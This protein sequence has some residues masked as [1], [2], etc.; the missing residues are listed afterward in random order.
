MVKLYYTPTSCGAASFIAA[1]ANFVNLDVEQV[2]L[3]THKT[4]S[5]KDYYKINPKG[6]V[7]AL[8]LDNGAVLNEGAAVLQWIADRSQ[9]RIA[10]SRNSEER[11]Y[12]QNAL[13]Y[14]SSEVHPAIGS[15]FAPVGDE[16]KA[17]I[18]TRVAAKLQFVND[19]LIGTKNFVANN[20]KS[21]ADY[22]LYICLTWCPFVGIDLEPYTNITSYVKK[23]EGLQEVKEARARMALNPT[24]VLAKEYYEVKCVI[25]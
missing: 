6:N 3:G 23:M 1:Y 19:Q 8:V 16:V 24:K 25:A 14:I 22:Y 18:Q 2:D 7:P 17:H 20:T 11:Y 21:V 15:F 9:G 5:G 4:S 10:P 12:F 13:N